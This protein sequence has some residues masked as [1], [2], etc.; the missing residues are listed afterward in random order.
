MS[1]GRI[2]SAVTRGEAVLVVIWD[3][4]QRAE[5][6]LGLIIAQRKVLAPLAD[7][8]AFHHIRIAE[9][10]WS[11]EWPAVG[12]D[13]GAAQLRRWADEQAGEAMPAEAF[14]AWMEG[15]GLTLDRAAEAL[16]LSR[17]TV[18]YY[19]SGEQPV[20]KTVMLATEGYDGRRAA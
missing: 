18:A 16:G 4:G 1:I 5:I 14:R 6:N 15:H 10:G 19:L 8:E 17:R 13:F 11:V 3:D 2:E 12:I 20:P 9:D 7:P